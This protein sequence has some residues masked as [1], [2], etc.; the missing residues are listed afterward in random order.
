MPEIREHGKSRITLEQLLAL[1]RSEKPRQE[2][3]EEFDQEFQRRRLAAL[4]NSV[5]WYI[6]AG[7]ILTRVTRVAAPLSAVA[8]ALVFGV[9]SLANRNRSND[10]AQSPR[11]AVNDEAPPPSYTLL[12]E[13]Y[14]LP[15][16]HIE[17]TS[18]IAEAPQAAG[19]LHYKVR[20][21]G[22]VSNA[23]KQ[24][25]TVA[26]PHVLEVSD[27]NTS[28]YFI[29]TLTASPAF[30]LGTQDVPATF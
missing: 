14:I 7:R 21:I 16:R 8:A 9:F 12:E 25:V 28:S 19:R 26:A 24:F 27:E 22:M 1:K 30:G 29:R 11:V 10:E 23:P 3:W 6:S 5:P 20:E 15:A 18:I 2:F 13:E 17:H 4:V